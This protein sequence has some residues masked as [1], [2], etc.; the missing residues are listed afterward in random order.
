MNLFLSLITS[1]SYECLLFVHQATVQM[2]PSTSSEEAFLL[3]EVN[4]P[5]GSLKKP[6]DCSE[7]VS[8]HS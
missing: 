2:R 1:L 6:S 8:K 4:K 7:V 5:S 3:L